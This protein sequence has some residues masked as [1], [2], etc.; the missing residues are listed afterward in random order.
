MRTLFIILAFCSCSKALQPKEVAYKM[1]EG[2]TAHD[3]VYL[4]QAQKDLNE[5]RKLSKTH[6]N[7]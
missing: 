1:P 3:S 7:K 6:K 2:L 4:F 5:M